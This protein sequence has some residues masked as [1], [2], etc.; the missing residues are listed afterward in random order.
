MKILRACE[1]KGIIA[2][3]I[4]Q[5]RLYRQSVSF[6][7]SIALME[8]GTAPYCRPSINPQELGKGAGEV[9]SDLDVCVYHVG[10]AERAIASRAPALHGPSMSSLSVV[11]TTTRTLNEI[12]TV[13]TAHSFRRFR[14]SI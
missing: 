8:Q 5:E 12:Q 4:S 6:P 11:L 1:T 2:D 7:G 9:G 10:Q 13:M 14:G 3:E